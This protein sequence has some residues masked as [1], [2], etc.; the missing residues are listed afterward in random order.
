MRLRARLREGRRPHLPDVP[1]DF[2]A[3]LRVTL[4]GLL[5]R[6]DEAEARL[7]RAVAENAHVPVP[8]EAPDFTKLFVVRHLALI[9]GVLAAAASALLITLVTN[10]DA[11]AA[12]L[13]NFIGKE[14]SVK[15]DEVACAQDAG[16]IICGPQ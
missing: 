15:V 11:Q 13:K 3:R 7:R 10:S 1:D 12:Q 14:I 8:L 4:D 5:G 6:H 9:V 16:Q 2:R